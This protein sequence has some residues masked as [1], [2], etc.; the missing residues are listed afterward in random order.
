MPE[1]SGGST[2]TPTAVRELRF[3]S[4]PAEAPRRVENLPYIYLGPLFKGR[5][6]T[7]AELKQRLQNG[8][9]QAIHGLGGVGKTRLAIEYAWRYAGDY[10]ALLFA[11]ARS[12]FDLRMNLAGFCD[13][14]V[15]DLP[16]R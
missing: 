5:D 2:A 3:P 10:T 4:R 8:G 11:S 6:V 7:L 13:P 16:E 9:C 12:A 15:L 14:L 1:P